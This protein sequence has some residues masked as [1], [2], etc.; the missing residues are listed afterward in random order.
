V[1]TQR[2]PV[3]RVIDLVVG[4]P[5]AAAIAARRSIPL[6]RQASRQGVRTGVRKLSRRAQET[7][8]SD[9]DTSDV[10]VSGVG[11]DVTAVPPAVVSEPT[12]AVEPE[13][14]EAPPLPI[15]D[16]D[17]L[18]ARQVVDRLTTLTDAE[19]SQVELYERA[20]R[21]RQTVLGRIAQL[22]S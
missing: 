2:Q 16:Y 7:L 9:A 1:V 12:P 6:I 8:G 11:A 5:V 19:L 10:P 3:D 13:V 18:A 14:A 22:K 15:D 20:H 4:L 21:H 17:H